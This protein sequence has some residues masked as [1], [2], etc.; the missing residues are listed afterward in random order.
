[1]ERLEEQG[2]QGVVHRPPVIPL[3]VQEAKHA[4]LK[5]FTNASKELNSHYQELK[6]EGF[7]S[8]SLLK[9]CVL[10]LDE[11]SISV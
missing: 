8:L 10:C 3:E 4:I 9:V 2:S 7:H 5:E 1:M 11:L 6:E